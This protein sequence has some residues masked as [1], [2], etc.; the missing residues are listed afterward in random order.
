[1]AAIVPPLLTTPGGGQFAKFNVKQIGTQ[2]TALSR[3]GAYLDPRISGVLPTI[4]EKAFSHFE[5]QPIT[6]ES[7]AQFNNAMMQQFLTDPKK[8]GIGYLTFSPLS[9]FEIIKMLDLYNPTW[10]Q[11]EYHKGQPWATAAPSKALY[12][13]NWSDKVKPSAYFSPAIVPYQGQMQ[14]WGT[15]WGNSLKATFPSANDYFALAQNDPKS[16]AL[17][18]AA[19]AKMKEY[20]S[21]RKPQ[22]GPWLK[23]ERGGRYK[24]VGGKKVYKK[25]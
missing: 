16:Q 13:P 3:G 12:R 2:G 15:Q 24:M 21:P 5:K 8:S 17:I 1:M 23:G 18:Q 22:K 9:K 6:K 4:W 11:S 20:K 25:K 19:Y 14:G 7:V 10:R